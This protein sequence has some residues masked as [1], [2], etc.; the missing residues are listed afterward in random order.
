MTRVA[1]SLVGYDRATERLAEEFAL[2]NAVL[3]KAKE[4]AHVPADDPDALGCY[5][6]DETGARGLTDILEATIDTECRDYFLE[7]FAVDSAIIVAGTGRL[8]GEN[9]ICL[10]AITGMD[11]H[12]QAGDFHEILAELPEPDAWQV[13][14]L[15]ARKRQLPLIS[16][17]GRIDA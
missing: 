13:A 9:E 3:P 4:F 12:L 8:D 1:H 6:L 2:P 11:A 17:R 5:P 10:V 16:P 7:G 15:E 14:G